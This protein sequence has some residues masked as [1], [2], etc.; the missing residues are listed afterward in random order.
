MRLI[1]HHLH[2][3]YPEI[4]QKK[5]IWASDDPEHVMGRNDTI[6]NVPETTD[7]IL[8][9]LFA[10]DHFCAMDY[11]LLQ[12]SIFIIDGANYPLSTWES[13]IMHMLEELGY[14]NEQD[15]VTFSEI[16]STKTDV[17]V[18]GAIRLT[19]LRRYFV[20]QRGNSICGVLACIYF[21]S[22][23]F[24][25]NKAQGYHTIIR[26]A[27]AINKCYHDNN[28]PQ[29]ERMYH[30]WRKMIVKWYFELM[31]Q[32]CPVLEDEQQKVAVQENVDNEDE[33]FDASETDNHVNDSVP[34]KQENMQAQPLSTIHEESEEGSDDN[35]DK[36]V[37][38]DPSLSIIG[39]ARANRMRE[40]DFQRS[41][42]RMLSHAQR[43]EAAHV[44]HP[45]TI[46]KLHGDKRDSHKPHGILGVVVKYS[47]TGGGIVVMTDFGIV[48][49]SNGEMLYV[50]FDQYVVM[51]EITTLT[52]RLE[53]CRKS[54]M[55]QT[56]VAE[57]QVR[58]SRPK[59]QALVR[60]DS[61]VSTSN[62]CRC[63]GGKCNKNCG[64]H[65]RRAMCCSG[66]S[67]SGR[68]EQSIKKESHIGNTAVREQ[69]QQES[70]RLVQG[71]LKLKKIDLRMLQWYRCP[72]NKNM[73]PCMKCDMPDGEIRIN[74]LLLC[75]DNKT[76][77]FR[78]Y[79]N[80]SK[81][82]LKSYCDMSGC[83]GWRCSHDWNEK[84]AT[85]YINSLRKLKGFKGEKDLEYRL[86]V[87]ELVLKE[88]L[89][90]ARGEAKAMKEE[91]SR[92]D[93]ND[94]DDGE[95][96]D[97]G[98]NE[99]GDDDSSDNN[100]D[101]GDDEC[102][103][104]GGSDN[105]DT[106]EN[107]VEE[108][109]GDEDEDNDEEEEGNGNSTNNKG[110]DDNE[111]GVEDDEEDDVG[112]DDDDDSDAGPMIMSDSKKSNDGMDW[113]GTLNP[114]VMESEVM[115]GRRTKTSDGSDENTLRAGD[116]IAYFHPMKVAEIWNRIDGDYIMKI[117]K[118]DEWVEVMGA[119]RLISKDQQIKLMA[120]WNTN[121]LK[122]IPVERKVKYRPVDS[123][124]IDPSLNGKFKKYNWPTYVLQQEM[125][126]MLDAGNQEQQS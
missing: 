85:K 67:C 112:F 43:D 114:K 7:Q 32:Y 94:G 64:C 2:A 35:N 109:C 58:F 31:D 96:D 33:W 45:G 117:T 21:A 89:D 42:D 52:D 29:L 107:N 22:R 80:V 100:G 18:N 3:H 54:I 30:S 6:I 65:K 46:V 39:R 60:G 93:S 104:D 13:S 70:R 78:E 101:N 48:C 121:E 36:S 9:L 81:S 59:L 16:D 56:F 62:R 108:S 86:L 82:E 51:S 11:D 49:H 25:W 76:W 73:M 1:Y 68:C 28:I 91:E 97:E 105:D 8:S 87:Q 41:V 37:R 95:S 10:E 40:I 92:D 119:G 72:T 38:M 12:S 75:I 74:L 79:K 44:V 23:V 69:A 5:M 26:V 24:H 124:D 15:S 88:L 84:L 61:V 113:V 116:K 14:V 4:A 106:N 55:N 19:I 111:S 90:I 20:E 98:D 118:E 27:N 123:F 126:A 99:G 50:P 71:S 102:C 66:C 110:D 34:S 115:E 120:K 53:K 77:H 17:M 122:H 63:K 125:Q 57:T 103:D 47:T 83:K